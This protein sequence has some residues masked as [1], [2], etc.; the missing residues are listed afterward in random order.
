MQFLLDGKVTGKEPD[1]V[2]CLK[3]TGLYFIDYNQ[4]T[5]IPIKTKWNDKTEANAV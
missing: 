2:M 1:W 5:F 3:E 4:L